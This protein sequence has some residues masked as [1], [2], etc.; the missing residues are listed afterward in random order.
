MSPLAI[1]STL[2]SLFSSSSTSGASQ[3]SQPGSGRPSITET[4]DFSSSLS[5]Q[6]AAL[7]T[8]P[9]SSPFG[10][11]FNGSKPSSA[12]DSSRG[13]TDLRSILD[14]LQSTQELPANWRK[15]TEH[16]EMAKIKDGM[17]AIQAAG[18]S[19]DNVSTST[20][21]ESIKTYLQ[22]FAAKYNE[23][24]SGVG[25][26]TKSDALQAGV[27]TAN[28]S[29][30]KIGQSIEKIFGSTKDSFHSLHDLGFSVD[31]NTNLASIDTSK[32]DALLIT[33]KDAAINSIHQFSAD[34]AKTIEPLNLASNL[35]S[36]PS[37]YLN[38]ALAAYAQTHRNA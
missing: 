13:L 10:P 6:L 31:P 23:W 16:P 24:I 2:F 15:L 19:L 4:G 30:N 21:I 22:T 9:A 8:S 1:I 28:A 26:T 17:A 36:I 5:A 18:K 27:Q 25:G 37:A 11:I 7:Q 35:A 29:L 32:L 12:V 34:F 14:R 33:Q 38:K 3:P 20:D